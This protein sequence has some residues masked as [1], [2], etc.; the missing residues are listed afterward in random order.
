[1]NGRAGIPWSELR[2]L[3]S[4]VICFD[5]SMRIIHASDTV[6]NY[7]PEV[8]DGPAMGEVFEVLRPGKLKTFSDALASLESLC[9]MTAT[10]GRFAIR[11]QLLP[12]IYDNQKVMCLCGAPWLFW[13][14]SNCPDIRLSLGDFAAQDVQ[15]DQLF[16]MTTEKR[17]VADL[18][19]LNTELTE[20]K[21]GLEEA[22]DAQRRFFAQMSHE[23]RTPLNGVVSALSLLEANSLEDRQRQLVGLAQSSS[24]NLM[25]VINYVLDLSKLELARRRWR[26]G[27]RS[28]RADPLNHRHPWGQSA[29]KVA[30]PHAGDGSGYP[31]ALQR[32]TPRVSVR[33]YST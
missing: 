28:P 24:R 10:N 21:D 8:K 33:H 2:R 19:N 29:R 1:M 20:A 26:N 22:H 30:G 6:H 3:F 13:M 23:M 18:E 25:D 31:T 12:T 27:I 32:A 15:L 5:E 4:V 11:G 14:S 17:M 16:F 7:L 9:L